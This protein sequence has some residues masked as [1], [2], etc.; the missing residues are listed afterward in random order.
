MTSS[1]AA[2][3]PLDDFTKFLLTIL[4]APAPFE[5]TFAF[6]KGENYDLNRLWV[7]LSMLAVLALITVLLRGQPWSYPQTVIG[8]YV[9]VVGGAMT[10]GGIAVVVWD[11]EI[12]EIM[13]WPGGVEIAVTA[14]APSVGILLLLSGIYLVRER[15]RLAK[16]ALETPLPADIGAVRVKDG[17][18]TMATWQART[19][20]ES[21]KEL[22]PLCQDTLDTEDLHFVAYFDETGDCQFYVDYFDDKA[23][24]KRATGDKSKRRT[25]YVRQGR[26]VRHMVGKLD[27]RFA[28]LRTGPLVRVVL[29]VE[30]GALFYYR[31]KQVGFLIGVTLDQTKV[32][33]TDWKLSDL[34]NKLLLELGLREEDDF[35]RLCPRC[36][37]TNRPTHP[38]KAQRVSPPDNVVEMRRPKNG[39]DG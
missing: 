34:A 17:P 13:L 11:D 20:D 29:D 27:K 26:H 14:L 15:G 23:L 28:D 39:T 2:R 21:A 3:K 33:P 1:E 24:V 37:E 4:L 38:S 5:I 16:E 35:Y 36:G 10:L 32:D 19:I 7:I 8:Y 12:R 18:H 22:I 31:L 25:E 9:A 6:I 30:Q